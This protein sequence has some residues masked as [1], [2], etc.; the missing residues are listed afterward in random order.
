MVGLIFSNLA[1]AFL[2]ITQITF[3]GRKIK[4]QKFSIPDICTVAKVKVYNPDKNLQNF[5]CRYFRS[6]APT[7]CLH[8]VV[9]LKFFKLCL[10]MGL[11]Q[12]YSLKY[13]VI[14]L[15]VV[16]RTLVFMDPWLT[17][18]YIPT[19]IQEINTE[20]GGFNPYTCMM[21]MD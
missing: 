20:N 15:C 3:P 4:S 1:K 19:F 16:V 14:V 12:F 2:E 11:M 7:I 10:G 13:C 6:F 18:R 21:Y 17:L 9:N 5:I 8:I